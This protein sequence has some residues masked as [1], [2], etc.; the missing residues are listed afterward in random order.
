MTTPD[1][2]ADFSGV[3]GRVDTTADKVKADFSGVSASVDTTA[4][5]TGGGERTGSYGGGFEAPITSQLAFLAT[6][7][8]RTSQ[9]TAQIGQHQARAM[10]W[11]SE[12]DALYV[13]GLGSVAGVSLVKPQGA[14]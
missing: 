4:E 12:R 2:N 8:E 10:A 14:F 9:I 6:N 7:G 11:D 3:S 13:V 5:K 1:K